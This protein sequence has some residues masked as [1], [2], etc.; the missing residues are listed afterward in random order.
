MFDRLRVECRAGFKADETPVRITLNERCLEIVEVRDR[1]YDP[2]ADYFKLLA[3]DGCLYL[4]RH[5]RSSDAWSLRY[6]RTREPRTATYITPVA[7][8]R[9][10]PH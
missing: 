3:E 2:E 5:D 7:G 4:L 1:W 6:V 8:H 10:G 9:W